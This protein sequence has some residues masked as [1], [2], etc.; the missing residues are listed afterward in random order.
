MLSGWG[1]T[2][3][4]YTGEAIVR[5][6][7]DK[8]LS[9]RPTMLY[10]T[11]KPLLCECDR[12]PILS[13]AKCSHYYNCWQEM[14]DRFIWHSGLRGWLRPMK[15]SW[16][17]HFQLRSFSLRAFCKYLCVKTRIP[18]A[19]WSCCTRGKLVCF[20][21]FPLLCECYHTRGKLWE[22]SI[23]FQVVAGKKSPFFNFSERQLNSLAMMS[24]E[25]DLRDLS[26][27]LHLLSPKARKMPF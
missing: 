26:N 24:I 5:Y 3:R 11:V 12:L 19:L 7:V 1:Q 22:Q 20:Q 23:V 6:E 2:Y 4:F 21:T 16:S 9:Q 25:S 18:C 27:R 10:L 14:G 13:S 17:Q 8:R 15:M